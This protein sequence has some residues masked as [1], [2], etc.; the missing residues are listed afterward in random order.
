MDMNRMTYLAGVEE[1]LIEAVIIPDD[2]TLEQIEKMFDAARRGLGLVNKLKNP[3]DKKK[4][5][6]AVLANLNKIRGALK[7]VVAA[8]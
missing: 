4:H 5:A 7:R 2:V 1:T 6:S 3:I 8:M